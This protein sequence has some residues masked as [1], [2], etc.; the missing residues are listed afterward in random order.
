MK[1]TIFL[2]ILGLA[3]FTN[4]TIIDTAHAD[5]NV[6]VNQQE[7]LAAAVQVNTYEELTNVLSSDNGI[8]TVLLGNDI[9]L[10]NGIKIHPAKKDLTIDG[11]GHTLTEATTGGH[12]TIY[13]DNNNGTKTIN[14]ANLSIV[15]KNYYGPVNVDDTVYGVT[16]NYTNITYNGPQLVHNIHGYATFSG[17]TKAAIKQVVSGSDLAQ[18]FAEVLGI[19]IKGSFNLDHQAALDS[20]FWFGLGNDSTPYFSIDDNADV[21]INVANNTLFYVDNSSTKPLD[22]TVGQSAK[23]KVTTIRELF[24]LGNAGDI[25]FQNNSNTRIE[26]STNTTNDP[27]LKV[28][29]NIKVNKA[30]I[31]DIIHAPETTASKIVGS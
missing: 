24:R 10:N 21:S 12:G 28:S 7:S 29:G 4:L 9:T 2:G 1:K 17:T 11:Q 6:N 3:L 14:L 8:T 23:F 18:E 20:A 22:I 13:V 16:L 31:F 25:T 27:T 5:E 30:A 19:T 15:G 26:R